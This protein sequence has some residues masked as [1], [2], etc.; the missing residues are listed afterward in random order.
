MQLHGGV[1]FPVVIVLSPPKAVA[2]L[3]CETSMKHITSGK[4]HTSSIAVAFSTWRCRGGQ[5]II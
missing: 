4:E 2:S 5:R 1:S 3:M